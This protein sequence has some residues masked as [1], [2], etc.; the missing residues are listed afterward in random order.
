MEGTGVEYHRRTPEDNSLYQVVQKNLDT[1][2]AEAATA[3]CSVPAFVIY[4]VRRIFR[5]ACEKA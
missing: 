1:L 3:E 2:L 5:K 4:R